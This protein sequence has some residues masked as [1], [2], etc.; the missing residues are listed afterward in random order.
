MAMPA[1]PPTRVAMVP[2]VPSAMPTD[3]VQEKKKL[4]ALV[5]RSAGSCEKVSSEK[6]SR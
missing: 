5:A 3:C 1:R 2:M 4:S 6:V